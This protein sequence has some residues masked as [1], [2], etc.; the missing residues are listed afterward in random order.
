MGKKMGEEH[1]GQHGEEM[2]GEHVKG[3]IGDKKDSLN[4]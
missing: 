1:Q 2:Q 4:V 3:E